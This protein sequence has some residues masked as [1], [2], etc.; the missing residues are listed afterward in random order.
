MEKQ[1]SL[2]FGG[3]KDMEERKRWLAERWCLF[4]NHRQLIAEILCTLAGT[5]DQRLAVLSM[6]ACTD[7]DLSK[8]TTAYESISL[9]VADGEG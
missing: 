5:Q 9:I 8:L 7:I 2:H 4:K 1:E 6:G 3:A